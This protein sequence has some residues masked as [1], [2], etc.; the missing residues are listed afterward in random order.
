MAV[1]NSIKLTNAG[2][3][4]NCSPCGEADDLCAFR[5]THTPSACYQFKHTQLNLTKLERTEAVLVLY[6]LNYISSG[7]QQHVTPSIATT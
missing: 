6:Q 4:Y 3:H 1:W 5:Y 2:N 7:A